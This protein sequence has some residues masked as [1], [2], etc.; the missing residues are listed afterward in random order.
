M[1]DNHI[2]LR[3]EIPAKYKWNILAVYPSDEAWN[4]D[5]KS[6]DEMIEPLNK[7]KGKLNEGAD[8]VVEAF[9]IKDQ[10]Q[11]KLEKLEVYAKVNHFIDKTDSIH[12]AIYDRIYS[13]FSEVASQTSW[14]RPELLSLPDDRLEEYRKFEG[15]QFWLRTYD[16]IIRYKTHTLSKEEEGILSLAGSALQTSADTYLLLTDADMKYG[17][18]VDDEGNEV[19]LSN[20]NYIKFLHSL[21]RDVRKGAWMAVYNAHIALKN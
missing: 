21:N 12:L 3:S 2:P 1:T 5:Y 7:L 10:I 14:I 11:E 17:N 6:I 13:K 9:K 15:M 16:E 19:E 4:E 20:G 8:R 18:V